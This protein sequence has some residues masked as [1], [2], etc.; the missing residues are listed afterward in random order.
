MRNV[1]VKVPRSQQ[2]MVAAMVRTIFA[3]PDAKHVERQLKEVAATL[4]RQF[5]H[6]ADMLLDAA[7]EVGV[8]RAAGPGARGVQESLT[9]RVSSEDGADAG[10]WLKASSSSRATR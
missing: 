10:P 3:R 7:E 5:P 2:L 4:A 9:Q 1:L 8:E 6:V